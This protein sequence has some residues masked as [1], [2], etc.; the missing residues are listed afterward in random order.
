MA[1]TDVSVELFTPASD[2]VTGV[3]GVPFD[4][5]F[6][7]GGND[8]FY[9]YDPISDAN[10]PLNIDILFGDLFDNGP[11][12]FAVILQI[13]AGDPFAILNA[14]LDPKN[15]IIPRGKNRFVLGDEFQPYY[16]AS[17]PL[18][19]L[20]SNQF[21]FNEFSVIYDFDPSWD[22]IQLNGKK[23]NYALL[24]VDNLPFQ[25]SVFSGY[26][27]FSLQAGLPDLVSLIV[28]KPSV[29]LN[30]KDKYFQFVGDKPKDKPQ[31]KK[32]GQFGTTGLDFGNGVATDS[33]GSIYVTGSTSG[34]LFGTNNGSGDTWLAKY[35]ASGNQKLG[36]QL[37]SSSGD[38]ANKVVTDKDGNFY[39]AGSTGGSFVANQQST[40]GTDAWVGKYSS[41]G[42]LLWGRQLGENSNLGDFGFSTSGFGLQVDDG[43]NVY[44]SGLTIRNNDTK[45]NP[46]TGT[47]F[48]DFPVEDDSW[49]IK[50]DSQGD[51]QWFTQIKDPNASFPLSQ[52]PFF[53]ENY[54]LAIDKGG[55][56][57]LVGW[58]QGLS[59]EADP[60]RLLLKYDA[61]LS[62]VDANGVIQWT[63]QFGS[64]DE[65]LDFAWGVDTDS[66]GNIYVTGWT[67]GT[68]GSQNSGSYDVWLAKFAPTLT[69][70]PVTGIGSSL[71]WAKQIG[72]KGDD[73]QFQSDIVID[74][75][76]NIFVSGY[77]NNK[78]GSGST[79]SAGNAWVGRFD[80]N[81]NNKWI[82]LVGVKDKAD[83]ATGLAVNNTGQV[84]V[85]GF[86][87]G[88]LGT[89]NNSGAQGA[90][91]DAWVAQL[92]VEKGKLQNFVGNTGSPISIGN[93][94]SIPSVDI[95]NRLV[96]ADKLPNGDNVIKTSGGAVDYGQ[97]LTGLAPAFDP[98]S[99]NSIT[100][101][102]ESS[103]LLDSSA[104]DRTTKVD[105]KGTDRDDVYFG[106]GADDKLE[107]GK[108]LDLLYGRAGKDGMKGNEGNDTLYGGDG[109]DKLDGGDGDDLLY[110]DTGNDEV[111]G[112]KGIDI[113]TGVDL[114][115]LQP[116]VAEIDKLQGNEDADIFVLGDKIK[117]A[118]Y[119]GNGSRDYA[120]IDDFKLD[121]GDKIQLA[122]A[123]SYS[124][125][126]DISGLPKGVG[127]L[128]NDDL[129]GII[130]DV[131]GLSLTNTNVFT[132][133]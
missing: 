109:D 110:G 65:G 128:A 25:G 99:P 10:A 7:R 103:G 77:T 41:N 28:E 101:A 22:T 20:T 29:T 43:G 13:Q 97:L 127:I 16:T 78:L 88:F 61:W 123:A 80:T 121:Q 63:Q 104:L 40:G 79:D 17:N 24:K 126:T 86:A 130:K 38:S 116:G 67:T 76:D 133:V 1:T 3:D 34:S 131:K 96:T 132:F 92:D 102:L 53:D 113:L 111:K 5:V 14:N 9:S 30:L 100:T 15:Y 73:G 50:F 74:A 27:L 47:P 105:Y 72:S 52:T 107:G 91:V 44:L 18:S 64:K 36:L 4:L 42:T 48:L 90:A 51:Q 119:L 118:F 59:K 8:V 46:L 12:E 84:I 45:I 108:G 11:D 57:Y 58:T 55:N 120:L 33:S 19:L 6:G 93:P 98:K 75:A 31:D 95:S 70:D 129:I 26:G 21:G 117:G 114:N 35:D 83:Y 106:G 112:G 32:I 125:M 2:L 81:G 124:L 94:G 37:G 23:E 66:Q 71:V 85:T 60:S 89:A 115:S 87:E 82:Q 122:S 69:I 54:D 39:L 62:K 68:V 56:S 49:V